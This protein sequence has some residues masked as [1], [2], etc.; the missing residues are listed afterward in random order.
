LP[1]GGETRARDFIDKQAEYE[2]SLPGERKSA[3]AWIER[4]CTPNR[5]ISWAHGPH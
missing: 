4:R 5:E 1:Q 3:G 2:R